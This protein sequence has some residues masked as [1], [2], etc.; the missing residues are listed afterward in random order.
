[1]PTPKDLF[2][3]IKSKRAFE[4]ISITIKESILNGDLKPGEKLSSETELAHQFNV[5][6]HTIR[7]A[8]RLLE[9]SGLLTIKKGVNGGPIVTDMISNSISN[10][11][12]DAFQMEKITLEEL[13]TARLE[14]EMCILNRVIDNIKESDIKKLQ[15]NVNKAKKKLE[16]GIM[17][18]EENIQF[19]KLLANASK[20]HVFLIVAESITKV[21]GNFLQRVGPDTETSNNVVEFHE[22]IIEAIIK[23]NRD[24]AIN[25]LKEHLLEV[26]K[27]L[28]IFIDRE[29]ANI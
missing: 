6:R 23:K 25:L 3:P 15:E 9:L 2:G 1:M 10:L 7:E 18:T 20:N 5:S 22:K 28:Q 24:E 27:R 16:N 19:H 11:Y 13:T 12:S 21:L 17:A 4:E 14:I 26:E 8:L 29:K